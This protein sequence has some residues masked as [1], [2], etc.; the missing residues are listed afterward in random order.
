M[1]HS[2]VTET[3]EFW[4][5]VY[6]ACQLTEVPGAPSFVRFLER[7]RAYLDE[8]GQSE[9]L[10]SMAAGFHP[11]LPIQVAIAKRLRAET[12]R[13]FPSSK[14]R[15]QLSVSNQADSFVLERSE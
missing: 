15:R 2:T 7:P 1:T 6:D 9:A 13:E 14:A 5:A 3:P 10:A 4:R 12:Q 8:F 11:L